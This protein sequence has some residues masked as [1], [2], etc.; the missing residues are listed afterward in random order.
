MFPSRSQAKAKTDKDEIRTK[1]LY[2]SEG[3]MIETRNHKVIASSKFPVKG[4]NDVRKLIIYLDISSSYWLFDF[5]RKLSYQL[6]IEL[7]K[8]F[9]NVCLIILQILS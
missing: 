5:K 6:K 4:I 1:L 2:K 8:A 9:C 3:E 7:K